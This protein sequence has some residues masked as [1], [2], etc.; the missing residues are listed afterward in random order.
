MSLIVRIIR[1]T[2]HDIGWLLAAW[3]ALIAFL[4]Y[5]YPTPTSAATLLGLCLLCL[6]LPY[7]IRSKVVLNYRFYRRPISILLY[8]V[9]A[10]MIVMRFIGHYQV[11]QFGIAAYFS[12]ALG[13]IFWAASD[14]M[15]EMVD[16]LAFPTEFGRVPD[17]IQLFDTRMVDW[18]NCDFQ[19]RAYLFRF[20]YDDEWDYGITG[21]L[22]F[23]FG[24]SNLEGKPPEEI[25]AA[26]ADWYDREDIG[27]MI[28]AESEGRNAG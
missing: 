15:F 6:C 20:R 3:P 17:E 28:E 12:L 22:T 25:Y 23:A 10:A 27:G 11:F 26:Y 21:P 2:R 7:V 14:P 13:I 16:W 9:I 8:V 1:F 18:P 4:I 19:I 24:D 5:R